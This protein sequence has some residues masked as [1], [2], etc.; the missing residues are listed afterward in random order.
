MW[1]AA[2]LLFASAGGA[3][4]L[5][6]F[7]RHGAEKPVLT[8]TVPDKVGAASSTLHVDAQAPL[9]GLTSVTVSIDGKSVLEKSLTTEPWWSTS[10]TPADA[11]HVTAQRS[12]PRRQPRHRG[13]GDQP[14]DAAVARRH[15]KN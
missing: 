13:D 9:W 8:L 2:A 3:V 1:I 11:A 14:G 15:R 7:A 12:Q 4:A 5:F 10:D 6:S